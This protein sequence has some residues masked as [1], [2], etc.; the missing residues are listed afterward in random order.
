M[1]QDGQM[2]THSHHLS[3]RH[4]GGEVEEFINVAVRSTRH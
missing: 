2:L 3:P 4:G 1:V